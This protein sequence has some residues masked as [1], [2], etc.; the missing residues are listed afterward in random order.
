MPVVFESSSPK[1]T[2]PETGVAASSDTS[3]SSLEPLSS[4]MGAFCIKPSDIRFATQAANEN[5]ILF[6]RQHPITQIPWILVTGLLIVLPILLV[7]MIKT[8]IGT[9]FTVPIQYTIILLIFWYLITF[10][11]AF[12]SFILWYYNINI[13]TNERVV[14][15]DFIYLLVQEVSA[16]RIEQIEDVTYKRV[17][18]F[19]AFFDYGDVYVQT[20]GTERNIEFLKVPKPRQISKILIDLMG[21]A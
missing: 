11:Y 4:A 20:A 12:V 17:G 21:Q 6:L 10:A 16:T 8:I 1:S 15:I 5:I 9:A 7:P 13:V 19:A 3:V 18:S 2:P 14:D